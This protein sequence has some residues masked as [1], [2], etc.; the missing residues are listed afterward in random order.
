MQI[1]P[2]ALASSGFFHVMYR[3]SEREVALWAAAALG[4][5]AHAGPKSGLEQPPRAVE[6]HRNRFADGL[7]VGMVAEFF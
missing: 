2:L 1:Y 6:F 3:S 4:R 7:D 5:L